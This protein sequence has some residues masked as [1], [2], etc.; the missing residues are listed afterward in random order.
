MDDDKKYYMVYRVFSNKE[1]PGVKDNSVIYGWTGNKNILKA[2]FKQRDDK[3]YMVINVRKSQFE[4]AFH[5]YNHDTSDEYMINILPLKSAKTHEV[6]NLFMTKNEMIEVE[7]KVQR[8]FDD[9]SS[10]EDIEGKDIAYYVNMIVNLHESY[11]DALF[12]LGYRPKEIEAVFDSCNDESLYP[13]TNHSFEGMQCE[14]FYNDQYINQSKELLALQDV[15]GKIV[16]SIESFVK[17]M[18]EDL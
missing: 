6:F 18:R 1:R 13:S 3:K 15:A 12:Y 16:Y 10:L 4:E 2:F 8:I 14:E 5:T 17:V 11:Y 7:K 9:L